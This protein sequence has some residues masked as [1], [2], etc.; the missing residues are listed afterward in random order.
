MHMFWDLIISPLLELFKPK[1]IIEIGSEDGKNTEQILHYCINNNAVLYAIDPMPLFDYLAWREKYDKHLIFYKTL[2]HQ[3]LPFIKDMDLVLI[4]GDHNWYTVFNELKLIEKN[5]FE[6]RTVFPLVL[7][8]DVCWPYGRR[9]IYYNPDNIPQEFRK[10]YEKMGIK[11]GFNKL[12][13]EG[14]INSHLFNSL[15]EDHPQNGVL[16]AVEDFLNDTTM[17]L[18]FIIL[19]AFYGLGLLFDNSLKQNTDFQRIINDINSSYYIKH[20]LEAVEKDRIQQVV[21]ISNLRNDL[22]NFKSRSQAEMSKLN[23]DIRQLK[24]VADERLLNLNKIEKDLNEVE[25]LWQSEMASYKRASAYISQL[26][27]AY[28]GLVSSHRWR[29]GNSVVNILNYLRFKRNE[30]TGADRMLII[31]KNFLEYH[32]NKRTDTLRGDRRIPEDVVQLN[33]IIDKLI[34][35]VG[36][37]AQTNRWKVG[38]LTLSIPLLFKNDSSESSVLV[39]ID[40]IKTRYLRWNPQ[41]E[42]KAWDIEELCEL[43]EDLAECYQALVNSNKWKTGDF[44]VSTLN[45]WIIKKPENRLTDLI[46]IE[47]EKYNQLKENLQLK[48]HKTSS[49]FK[50]PSPVKIED[51]I[52]DQYTSD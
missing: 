36:L 51:A 8:H 29:I 31:F 15:C 30:P 21:E 48:N 33:M 39:R 17:D 35:N 25:E 13:K 4:D 52:G 14:G 3:A 12:V 6:S 28:K 34:K 40:Q 46:E 37:L 9:D 23:H 44:I 42:H 47:F 43:I 2:S 7:I 11:P 19:P 38:K 49:F 26:N 24:K 18:D 10:P 5:T 45:R 27:D 1:R 20:F 22:K 41:P 50:N 16:T 32:Q